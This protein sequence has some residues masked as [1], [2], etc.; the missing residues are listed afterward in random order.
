MET[1]FSYIE[2]NYKR[3]LYN[4][5]E[6]VAKYRKVDDKIDIIAVTK[7]VAPEA[8]NYAISCGIKKIG[9]NRVQEFLVKKDYYN[10]KADIHFIGHLQTNK[11][12]YLIDDVA[13]IQSVDSVKIASEINKL[14][15][16]VGKI[17]DVLIEVN[18]GG[19]ESKYGIS[20]N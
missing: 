2:E 16:R 9:E 12:R 18:I 13:L 14:A 6:S 8:V 4:V 5:E 19:E 17:Q 3:I 10:K 15:E 20:P 11:V 7:T 1:S